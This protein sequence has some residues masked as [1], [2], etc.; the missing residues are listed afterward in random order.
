MK[1]G[2]Y[3]YILS[4]KRN[5]TLYVG[6]TSD[7]VTRIYQHREHLVGGFTSKYKVDRL[8]WFGECGS[9]LEAIEL[10]K[11]IKNRARKWKLALIEELNPE[12]QD[13]AADWVE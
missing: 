13:L 10:E 9:I 12:W 3:V 2:A 8:V 5:G 6:V 7:L 1:R 4:S 11:K